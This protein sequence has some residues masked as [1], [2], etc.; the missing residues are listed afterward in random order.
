MHGKMHK[1]A[2]FDT[3]TPLSHTCRFL[4]QSIYAM[5]SAYDAA[6]RALSQQQKY[7]SFGIRTTYEFTRLHYI[8]S[9]LRSVLR[10]PHSYT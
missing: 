8:R 4:V 3:S 5:Y 7:L 1:R 10:L 2:A 6:V 9:G